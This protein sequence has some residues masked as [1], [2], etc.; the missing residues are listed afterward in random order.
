[1]LRILARDLVLQSADVDFAALAAA[2]NQTGIAEV[3][4]LC[5]P[6]IIFSVSVYVCRIRCRLKAP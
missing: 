2:V 1:M 3:R 5:F 4:L 6:A